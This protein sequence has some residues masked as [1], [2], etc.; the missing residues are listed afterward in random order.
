[1][2]LVF[3]TSSI[4]ESNVQPLSNPL[5]ISPSVATPRSFNPEVIKHIP[6]AFE[7]IGSRA[8]EMVWPEATSR[9]EIIEEVIS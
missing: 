5:L 4:E 2:Q 8:Y 6:L 1:M 7:S 3:I 9:L